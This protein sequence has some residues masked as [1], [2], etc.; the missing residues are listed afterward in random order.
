MRR[1]FI[2]ALAVAAIASTVASGQST[3][4]PKRAEA[5][6]PA[7]VSDSASIAEARTLLKA[8]VETNTTREHGSTTA[9]ARLLAERFLQAGW[10][11]GDVEV[12]GPSPTRQNLVVRWRAQSP[13]A[14]PVLFMSHL[15]VVEARREDWDSD[16]FLLRE[17]DGY[18]Y[19]RGVLDDKAAVATWTTGLISL[20]RQGWRPAR[21]IVLLLTADEEGGDENG[22]E[23]LIRNRRALFD[24]DFVINADAAGPELRDG[25]VTRFMVDV[26]EKSP[27]TIDVTVTN[28]G[29]HSSRPRTDNAIYSLA[30]ALVR[31]E[32][33]RF[34]VQLSDL[35]RA[36]LTKSAE[37]APTD[38]AEALRQILRDPTD[39]A[40]SDV[41]V[42]VPHLNALLRTTC[43]AT[44]LSGG[45]AINALPQRATATVN[46]RVLPGTKPDSVLAQ[47]RRVVAD[48]AVHAVSRPQVKPAAPA[49]AM[50]DDVLNLLTR[51]IAP[52][53]GT[54]VRVQPTLSLGATD[55]SYTRLMGIPTYTIWHVPLDPADMRAHGRDE[56]ILARS[57]DESVGFARTLIREAAGRAP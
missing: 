53:W 47:L 44:E 24:V 35:Q 16:P 20:R 26:A 49:S 14:K 36:Q 37:S 43:V 23:W 18:L 21:D 15:D 56:R 46:C 22:I 13:A 51:A 17:K 1:D 57:F 39:S 45:H 11:A 42:R 32:Q 52:T 41:L 28:S 3:G 34:P 10:S 33:Y 6:G 48:T 30:H 8:L 50:R 40:A 25:K 19:G 38:V 9:A 27:V 5:A 54:S 4:A 2:S 7:I 29:G 31:I 12:V 55:G